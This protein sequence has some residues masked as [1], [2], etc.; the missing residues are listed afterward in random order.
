TVE[1]ALLEVALA[2]PNAT[3]ESL[4]QTC[5]QLLANSKEQEELI[6]ALLTLSRSQRGLDQRERF[7]LAAVSENVLTALREDAKRRDIQLRRWL[8]HAE[9]SGDARLAERLIVNLVDNGIRHNHTSGYIEVRTTTKADRS[10]VAVAN[11]GPVV[12]AEEVERLFQPFQR[13]G[14]ERT[15][16]GDGIGLGLS[17][18]AAVAAAHGATL[19]AEAQ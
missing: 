7:D 6:E 1:R 13:L 18:V 17:I 4:R 11:S 19:T 12:P 10:V 15:D 9:T 16:H 3:A 8:E 14:S 2:D 5:E